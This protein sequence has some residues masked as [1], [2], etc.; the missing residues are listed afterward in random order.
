MKYYHFS[1]IFFVNF[2]YLFCTKTTGNQTRCLD[3]C[4]ITRY[5]K[6][7]RIIPFSIAIIGITLIKINFFIYTT[8]LFSSI[9]LVALLVILEKI[10]TIFMS[11]TIEV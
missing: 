5:T 11:K 6:I 3:N 1:L 8:A 4:E 2:V 9:N 10:N 7:K